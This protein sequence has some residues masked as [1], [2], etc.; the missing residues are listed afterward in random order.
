MFQHTLQDHL[1]VKT[2]IIPS[3]L[4]PSGRS[5]LDSTPLLCYCFICVSLPAPISAYVFQYPG[6]KRGQDG[7]VRHKNMGSGFREARNH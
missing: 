5:I 6:I 7:I 3:V 2:F 4:E 1:I